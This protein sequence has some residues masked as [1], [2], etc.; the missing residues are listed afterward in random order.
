M[1][2]GMEV[3]DGVSDLWTEVGEGD[4]E[5]KWVGGDEGE[6]GEWESMMLPGK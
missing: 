4:R 2:P 5:K 1:G 6:E 3:G